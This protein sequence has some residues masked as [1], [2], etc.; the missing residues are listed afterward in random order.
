MFWL[1]N[2]LAYM[3]ELKQ[4]DVHCIY[5]NMAAGSVLRGL[6]SAD[7]AQL[8]PQIQL[9][10]TLKKEDGTVSNLYSDIVQGEKRFSIP[11]EQTGIHEI[12]FTAQE[13]YNNPA[14]TR[15]A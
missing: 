10:I 13:N 4:S 12:C 8:E 2:S 14:L 6:Y 15:K 9:D 1:V 11:I 7:Q 5:E 3:F